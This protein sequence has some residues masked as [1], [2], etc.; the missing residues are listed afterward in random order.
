M[1][2]GI[3]SPEFIVLA[4]ISSNLSNGL[5]K[6]NKYDHRLVLLPWA[7]SDNRDRKHK[8]CLQGGQTLPSTNLEFIHVYGLELYNLAAVN[9]VPLDL[10]LVLLTA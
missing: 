3:S 8:R 9:A 2:P 1:N 6:G 10:D 7:V 5:A 4:N